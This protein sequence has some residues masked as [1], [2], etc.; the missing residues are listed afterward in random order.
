AGTSGPGTA[1]ATGSGGGA[2]NTPVAGRGGGGGGAAGAAGTSAPRGGAGGSA[3]VT[4]AVAAGPR[5]SG[6]GALMPRPFG[7]DFAWGRQNPSGSGSL[8]SYNYLQMVAYW[9][10]SGIASSGSYSSCTGCTWLSSRVSGT[11]LIPVYY[12]Y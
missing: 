8:S 4:C 6:A 7:C 9:I 1:G 3:G 5:C 2:G 12:A 11:N 10:E